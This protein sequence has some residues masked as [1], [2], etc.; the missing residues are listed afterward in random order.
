MVPHARAG[1]G[2]VATQSY[3]NTTFGPHGLSLLSHRN[4]PEKVLEV[5][6]GNDKGRNKRQVGLVT[7]AGVAATYTGKECNAWAGG[8]AG[9]NYAVQGNIL[10]GEDVV[11]AMEKA[12][13]SSAGKGCFF[14]RQRGLLLCM[15]GGPEDRLEAAARAVV[16]V[17][18]TSGADSA[19]GLLVT[20]KRG[21]RWRS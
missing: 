1:V 4:P 13:L 11:V 17:G 20:M 21:G 18:E 14:E 10:T 19:V 15:M 12:F 9:P 3:A 16:S 6:L 2:A 7:A 5:L 8:R